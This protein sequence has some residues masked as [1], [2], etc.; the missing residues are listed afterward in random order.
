MAVEHAVHDPAQRAGAFA[1]DDANERQTLF[2]CG[3]Q[4]LLDDVLALLGEK[5]VEVEYVGQCR[6]RELVVVVQTLA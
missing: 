5:R 3:V 2:L 6:R 1:V 4:V